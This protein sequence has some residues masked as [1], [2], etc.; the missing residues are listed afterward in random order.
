MQ[1]C[2]GFQREK[3]LC[4]YFINTVAD[5]PTFPILAENFLFKNII[6]DFPPLSIIFQKNDY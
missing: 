3:L 1:Q 2:P 4:I 5:L 6:Y